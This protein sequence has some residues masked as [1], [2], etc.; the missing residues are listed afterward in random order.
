MKRKIL[1]PAIGFSVVM[2]A[3][4]S[5]QRIPRTP[6]FCDECVMRRDVVQWRLAG[7][8]NIFQ[9]TH[10]EATPVSELLAQL[11]V[12]PAHE[13][14]WT[15]PQQVAEKD[16]ETPD[17]PRIRSL[18][19][20]NTPRS[21][22]FLRSMFNYTDGRDITNWRRVAWQPTFASVLE[23]ALRFSR[24]PENGFATRD[25]FLNWWHANAYPLFNRLH[26]LTVAD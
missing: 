7:Q 1:L 5:I 21:V 11:Q 8:W 15:A 25:E 13:H 22:N 10:V 14:R 2:V 16:L 3:A 20:L 23:P 17:A 26:E 4:L 19:L 9:T 24:F 18:G 6:E 12:C